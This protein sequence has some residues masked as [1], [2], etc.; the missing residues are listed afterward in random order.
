MTKYLV[1]KDVTPNIKGFNTTISAHFKQEMFF[2]WALDQNCINHYL[3]LGLSNFLV[4]HFCLQTSEFLLSHSLDHYNNRLISKEVNIPSR[5]MKELQ[6]CH[7]A[8][9]ISYV[10]I[11][12]VVQHEICSLRCEFFLFVCFIAA[13]SR[14]KVAKLVIFLKNWAWSLAW[15]YLAKH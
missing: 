5:Q 3:L 9:Q 10:V 8:H 4:N 7:L 13:I 6:S 12:Y 2:S 14:M 11:P 1:I 15:M